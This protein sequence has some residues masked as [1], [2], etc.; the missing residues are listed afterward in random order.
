VKLKYFPAHSVPVHA[1]VVDEN[2]Q[3]VE[4]L[5]GRLYH[6]L[7]VLEDGDVARHRHGL[8]AHGADLLLV[9]PGFGRMRAVGEADVGPLAGQFER[10]GGADAL[11]AARDQGVFA[12]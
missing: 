12:F 1:G 5:Q 3:A 10:N 8:A 7:R 11:R 9:V 2:V 6:A 4:F